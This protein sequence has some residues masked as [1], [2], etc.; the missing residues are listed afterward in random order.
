MQ[1]HTKPEKKKFWGFW[2][3]FCFIQFCF[4]D[5][6]GGIFEDCILQNPAFE[7]KKPMFQ[8]LFHCLLT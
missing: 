3:F 4:P 8:F 2:G 1:R 5:L 7:V 6:V